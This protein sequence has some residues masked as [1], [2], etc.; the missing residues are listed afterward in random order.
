MKNTV[1]GVFFF[2]GK[3]IRTFWPTQHKVTVIQKLV[4]ASRQTDSRVHKYRR[5]SQFNGGRITFQQMVLKQKASH[6]KKKNFDPYFVPLKNINS[7]DILDLCVKSD[8]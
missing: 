5:E 7:Q 3:T 6:K 8:P 1:F 2:T 4:L